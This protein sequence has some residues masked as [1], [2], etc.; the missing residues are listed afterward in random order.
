MAERKQKN[1]VYDYANISSVNRGLACWNLNDLIEMSMRFISDFSLKPLLILLCL[2]FI[3]FKWVDIFF[4]C[5]H[6][7][8][9]FFFSFMHLIFFLQ[10]GTST[11]EIAIVE[12]VRF[13]NCFLVVSASS[14]QACSLLVFSKSVSSERLEGLMIN[15]TT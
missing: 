2:V 5:I 8:V 3:D 10:S 14:H 13:K 9:M 11:S 12:N 6:H 4:R 15:F 7:V 1:C